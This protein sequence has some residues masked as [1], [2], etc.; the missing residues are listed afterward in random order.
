MSSYR[1]GA[2]SHKTT[3]S[4]IRCSSEAQVLTVLLANELEVGESN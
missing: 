4:H 2:Q 1:F 3:F